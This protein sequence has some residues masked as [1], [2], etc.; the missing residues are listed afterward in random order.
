MKNLK[1]TTLMAA[2][3]LASTSPTQAFTIDSG[4]VQGAFT[5]SVSAGLQY[6]LDKLEPTINTNNNGTNK[7]NY[8]DK[9]IVSQTIK[10]IHELD[11]TFGSDWA[12]F[13]RATWLKDFK[14]GDTKNKLHEDSEDLAETDVRFLD[15]FVEKSYTMGEQFGQ[16]R[17]GNQVLNWGESLFHFGGINYATNPVDIQ[18]AVLPGGQIKEILVPVPMLTVNQGL[19]DTMSVEAYYQLDFKSHRFPPVDTFWSTTSLIG[20]GSQLTD[21]ASAFGDVGV[22]DDPD[23]DQYG[24]SLKFQPE[25]SI[26]EY[27]FYYAHYNEK[28]PWVRWSTTVNAN[29]VAF[30]TDANLT[31]AEGID[32]F[33]FSM[34][35]DVGEWAMGGEIAY[36]PNDV[37]ALDPFGSCFG[38]GT[39]LREQKHWSFDVTAINLLTPNGPMGW[40]LNSLGGNSGIFMVDVA[41]SYV[42]GLDPADTDV[43]VALDSSKKMSWGY[44]VEASV[45]YEGSLIPGWTVSPG[46]F[47]RDNVSGSS[48]ELLGWWRN[49]AKE[50]NAYVNF[51]NSNDVSIGVQYLGFWGGD[52][53]RV[54]DNRDKDVLAVTFSY[55]F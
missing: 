48:H 42:P 45:S 32:M 44:A 11:L 50:V 34:N 2:V 31:F 22:E 6:S 21:D 23:E 3:A 49:D 1:F 19:S 16:M 37:I 46:I 14:L 47:F 5:T 53:A 51:V 8:D 7:A 30:G 38:V 33:A 39:C 25:E 12:L 54:V 29:N 52:P 35:T 20:E 55:T 28:F 36:R 15:F 26:T 4:G 41:G 17:L 27:G 40:L 13:A 43:L 9:Q 10:G 18:R 24:F